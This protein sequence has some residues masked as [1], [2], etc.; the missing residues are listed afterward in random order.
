VRALII[1][2][3]DNV[4]LLRFDWLGCEP[5]GGFWANPGAGIEPEESR[6][7]ALRRGSPEEVGLDVHPLR[8]PLVLDGF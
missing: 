4:V 3:A 7:E 6:L 5:P 8:Q 1:D 2:E